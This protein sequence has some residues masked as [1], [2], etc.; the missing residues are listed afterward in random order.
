MHYKLTIKF[1]IPI[2]SHRS[3]PKSTEL[4]KNALDICLILFFLL[5][6]QYPTNIVQNTF[7]VFTMRTKKEIS[8]AR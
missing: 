5:T 7:F 3:N 2:G 6:I 1:Y 4:R 8:Y